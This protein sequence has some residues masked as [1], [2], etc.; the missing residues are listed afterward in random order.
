[1]TVLCIRRAGEGRKERRAIFPQASD[2]IEPGD[3]LIVFGETKRL[4]ELSA[5]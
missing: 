5:R 1:M 4:D 2:V 3:R